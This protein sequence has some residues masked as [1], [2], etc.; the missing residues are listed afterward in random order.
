MKMVEQKESEIPPKPFEIMLEL[1]GGLAIIKADINSIREQDINAN[2]M[3]NAAF[4]RLTLNIK[5]NKRL[6]SLPFCTLNLD[7][8]PEIISGHHRVRAAR[9]A[10]LRQIYLL[11]DT[12]TLS[13]SEII[14]KQLAHNA[15][16]GEDN[17]ETLMRLYDM[18][19]T[20]DL[21][22]ASFIDPDLNNAALTSISLPDVTLDY[23]MHTL[24]LVF[25]PHQLED[26][27]RVIA[28]LSPDTE[29]IHVAPLE[30]WSEFKEALG[31]LMDTEHIK[32]TGAAIARMAEI[33]KRHLQTPSN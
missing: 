22:V 11:A 1:P 29:A 23:E 6:E 24:S 26:F 28:Q 2:V 31:Q 16:R 5:H 9:K 14:S 15:I 10:G 20:A 4:E 7:N 27:E 19:E 33:V 17:Q 8:F 12:I 3:T 18:I 13:R 32:S 21:K 25:L 30:H